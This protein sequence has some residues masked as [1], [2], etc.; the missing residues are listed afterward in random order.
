LAGDNQKI[1]NKNSDEACTS[2]TGIEREVKICA[3]NL[4]NET[5]LMCTTAKK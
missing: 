4:A 3:T 2:V 1:C 5:K